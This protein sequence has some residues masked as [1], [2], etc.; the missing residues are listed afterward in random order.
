MLTVSDTRTPETDRSGPLIE[1]LL[2][3]AG[4]EI[5]DR[6]IVKDEPAQIE[7]A[8]SRWLSDPN[9]QAVV[10]TGGTGIARRDGTIEVVSRLLR[11]ELPGF[12]ELF[13]MLS[14]EQVKG[15]AMLSRAVAGV[16]S[17]AGRGRLPDEAA[18]GRKPTVIFALPGSTN[19]VETAV[20]HLIAPQLAHMIAELER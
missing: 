1:R 15:A 11:K 4:H 14:Y 19:A 10:T 2:T 20:T 13:R 17:P 8:L 9:V 7:E 18:D 16:A 6:A 3:G 5:V 12:G